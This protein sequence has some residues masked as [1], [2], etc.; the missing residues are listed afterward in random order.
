MQILAEFAQ[1]KQVKMNSDSAVEIFIAADALDVEVAREQA[2][3]F[4][5][6]R[7]LKPDKV[8]RDINA[9]SVQ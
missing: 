4:L 7:V 2:E 6:K 5:G 8:C 9:K 3:T 1:T